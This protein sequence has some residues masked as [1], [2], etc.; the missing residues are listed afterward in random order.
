MQ[1]RTASL[2]ARLEA[3]VAAH[4]AA[5]RTAE[6]LA[7]QLKGSRAAAAQ[8]LSSTKAEMAD[9]LTAAK[10]AA[11]KQAAKDERQVAA[12]DEAV[13][14]ADERLAAMQE[15][16]QLAE[17]V[18]FIKAVVL[19]YCSMLSTRALSELTASL[20]HQAAVRMYT[21]RG[22]CILQL[23]LQ[24]RG[25]LEGERQKLARERAAMCENLSQVGSRPLDQPT[26]SEGWKQRIRSPSIPPQTY[27][28][29]FE[30]ILVLHVN[31]SST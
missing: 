22:L 26:P 15:R 2:G 31:W 3:S 27:R 7:E 25:T 23:R 30:H 16:A 11:A 28:L 18:P 19:N 5:E 4:A 14:L 6:D 10:A 20:S 13:K 1:E 29:Q 8:L 12:A 17:V 21:I 9:K 24:E